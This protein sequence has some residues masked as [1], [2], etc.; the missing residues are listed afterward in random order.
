MV[1]KVL[2]IRGMLI[3]LRRLQLTFKQLGGGP[4]AGGGKA[5]ESQRSVDL[6]VF[7]VFID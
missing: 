5:P 3:C 7:G 2:V 6:G 1:C 4:G